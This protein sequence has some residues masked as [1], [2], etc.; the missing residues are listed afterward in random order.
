MDIFSFYFEGLLPE[1]PVILY[2]L[3]H[4]VLKHYVSTKVQFGRPML[5]H[6]FSFSLNYINIVLLPYWNSM[7]NYDALSSTT[8]SC[9]SPYWSL[10]TLFW[11]TDESFYREECFP[12][13]LRM[14]SSSGDAHL[15]HTL[16]VSRNQWTCPPWHSEMDLSCPSEFDWS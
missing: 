7:L 5:P 15:L 16:S 4:P 3:L 6:M 2:D 1:L 11:T 14:S 9:S 8:P 12:S 10:S 13:P